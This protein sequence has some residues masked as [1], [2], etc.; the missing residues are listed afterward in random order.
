MDSLIDAISTNR[1]GTPGLCKAHFG[2]AWGV[3]LAPERRLFIER[4]ERGSCWCI[5]NDGSDAPFQMGAGDV[6]ISTGE[7]GYALASTPASR[8]TSLKEGLAMSPSLQQ[9]RATILAGF[10]RIAERDGFEVFSELP[11]LIL[12]EGT[13]IEND[14][15]LSSLLEIASNEAERKWSGSKA[16]SANLLNT[17]FIALLRFWSDD[18]SLRNQSFDTKNRISRALS[19]L[20]RNYSRFWTVEKLA[21]ESAMS[22]STF[23]KEFADTVGET[24]LA[25]LTKFRM[26]K[27]S[28]LLAK[29]HLTLS[30]IAEQI[31]YTDE[32]S[33]NRAFKRVKGV[34]PGYYRSQFA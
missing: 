19:L 16:L 33:F 2:D 8:I 7:S 28:R 10:Y 29:Q 18:E 34:S 27:A 32:Y 26:E 12:I 31:G 4:V 6:I 9:S 23:A 15:E 14:R 1:I 22:R 20:H 13:G 24:P 17:L 5:P 30:Q 25:Y 3:D 11:D 21:R